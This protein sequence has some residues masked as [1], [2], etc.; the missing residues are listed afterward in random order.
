MGVWGLE[1][2]MKIFFSLLFHLHIEI[3]KKTLIGGIKK[4]P[5]IVFFE[6]QTWKKVRNPSQMYLHVSSPPYS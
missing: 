1:K 6:S 4:F 2:L 3:T 5:S